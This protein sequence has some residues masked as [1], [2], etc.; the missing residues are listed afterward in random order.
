MRCF[1]CDKQ[2]RVGDCYA[3]YRD[4]TEFICCDC[5]H[6]WF[7]TSLGSEH[8]IKPEEAETKEHLAFADSSYIEDGFGN[9]CSTIC[10][11]CHRHSME[12]VRPG[13]VQCGFCG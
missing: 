5:Y 12:V 1:F 13:K 7:G 11:D 6:A 10:P 9:S 3:F 8:V 2:F 4:S